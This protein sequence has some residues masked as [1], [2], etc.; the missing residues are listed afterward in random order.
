MPGSVAFDSAASYAVFGLIKLGAY[1]GYSAIV[2]TW[3]EETKARAITV[4]AARTVLGM[5][6]GGLYLF[7]LWDFWQT[8]GWM[9]WLCLLPVRVVEWWLV[10]RLFFGR[11]RSKL[12]RSIAIGF[13]VAVSF[14]ADIPAT[15]GWL[16]SGGFCVC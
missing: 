7:L 11:P 2:K 3:L 16:L 6:V 8:A 14:L 5:G 12:R 1:T 4:G 10:L 9:Y 13:G 15:L